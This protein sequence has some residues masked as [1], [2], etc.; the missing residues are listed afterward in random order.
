[1]KKVVIDTI[2]VS[3]FK[4]WADAHVGFGS[5]KAELIAGTGFGKTTFF[6]AWKWVL[7]L[8][9][10]DIEP[11]T[12]G[13]KQIPDLV[14]TVTIKVLID[15]L[16]YEL[17]RV[18]EQ[19][20]KVDKLTQE[21]S[22]NGNTTRFFVDDL[23]IKANIYKEKIGGLFG[24]EYDNLEMLVNLAYF[25]S[26][27]TGKWT[28]KERRQFL[29]TACAVDGILQC[30]YKD[31][32]FDLIAPL[33]EKGYST[34]EINKMLNTE[35]KGI[36][37]AKTKN[38]ILI[39]EKAKELGEYTDRDYDALRKEQDKL[40][41]RLDNISK[42]SGKVA[43]NEVH[44]KLVNEYTRV[45]A[46]LQRAVIKM[47]NENNELASRKLK[48]NAELHE[49][50]IRIQF[51]QGEIERLK[52][53]QS[54]EDNSIAEDENICP[55]CGQE[56]PEGII[57]GREEAN[58]IA[59]E[60]KLAKLDELV[61]VTK[62]MAHQYNAQKK[63]YDE[64]PQKGE[65]TNDEIKAMM[66]R[67]SELSKQMDDLRVADAAEDIE[68]EKQELLSKI[69]ELTKQLMGEDMIEKI[70]NSIEMYRQDSIDQTNKEVENEKKRRQLEQYI[71]STISLVSDKINSYFEGVNFR[72]FD[73]LTA[74][75]DKDIQEVCEVEYGGIGYG[76]LSNGQKIMANF[77][78]V[79]GLQ[80]IFNV[81]LPI[82][83][84][85]A[86]SITY[87]VNAEQQV[88]R[89]VT[90]KNENFSGTKIRDIV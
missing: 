10:P 48:M 78:T 31:E 29:F 28:W 63:V 54:T 76:S 52:F 43:K 8:N 57:A 3:N 15:N 17:K 14:T 58:R 47:T 61:R 72:L 40:T 70:K 13:N 42:K 6:D 34:L 62:E 59:R 22:F 41:K 45:D 79:K 25:N 5:D 24:I 74:N 56:L 90:S 9:V 80:K 44:A 65:M 85:E 64:L 23:E 73:V 77:L 20:W 75:A 88:I 18:S 51:N 71:L 86:Q 4:G 11:V 30:L 38:E 33:L 89:L 84:D 26:T 60:V 32:R 36:T 53:W 7:G 83:L 2:K 55:T 16:E 82:F 68:A 12:S 39:N 49:L 66:E 46:E 37:D 67:K 1:M 69:H 21:K 19:S 35:K 50:A 87:D 27:Q 81:S